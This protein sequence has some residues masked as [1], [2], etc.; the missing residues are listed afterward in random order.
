[1]MKILLIAPV[2]WQK[3]FCQI[4]KAAAKSLDAYFIFI[5]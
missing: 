1:M 2:D 3:K 5:N 4:P